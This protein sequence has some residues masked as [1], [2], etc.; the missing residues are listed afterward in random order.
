MDKNINVLLAAYTNKLRKYAR[1]V[2]VPANS[3]AENMIIQIA[4]SAIHEQ[5]QELIPFIKKA[6]M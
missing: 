5:Y 6:G 1:A 2:G 3:E 4:L